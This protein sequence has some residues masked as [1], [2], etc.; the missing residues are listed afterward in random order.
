M[1]KK[2]GSRDEGGSDGSGDKER[3]EQRKFNREQ[4]S[5]NN[6]QR[7]FAEEY[8]K[9][10]REQNQELGTQKAIQVEITQR[11]QELRKNT[12]GHNVEIGASIKLSKA[13]TKSL[14]D[15]ISAGKNINQLENARNKIKTQ[16]NLIDLQIG[17][18]AKDSGS[19]ADELVAKAEKHQSLQ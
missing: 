11:L 17:A 1:A 16:G 9:L 10:L 2:F 13:I 3:N 14:D 18:L 19:T 8:A 7:Q 12:T 15:S 6:D 5:S 4:K